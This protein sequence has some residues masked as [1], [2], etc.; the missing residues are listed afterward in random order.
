M[1]LWRV[2]KKY[3]VPC[4]YTELCNTESLKLLRTHISK[5][6]KNK[7]KCNRNQNQNSGIQSANQST[8]TQLVLNSAQNERKYVLVRMWALAST[9]F[10]PRCW[11][12]NS[13]RWISFQLI[14]RNFIHPNLLMVECIYFWTIFFFR[15]IQ[16]LLNA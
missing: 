15:L 3:L 4:L 13:H 1:F 14:F 7:K 8:H 16:F 9:S 5:L 10:F 6:N 11:L 12:I 2:V